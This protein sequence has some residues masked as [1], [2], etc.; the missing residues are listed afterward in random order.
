MGAEDFSFMLQKRPGCY[1][2]AGNG[3]ADG[4]RVLHNPHYDFND[5]LIPYGA[6][7]WVRIAEGDRV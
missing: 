2:W 6:A 4:Q 1:I 7:Y 5:D 3:S